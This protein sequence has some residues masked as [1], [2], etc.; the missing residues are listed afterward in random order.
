LIDLQ[1]RVA[2]VHAAAGNVVLDLSTPLRR[3]LD[4]FLFTVVDG[5]G[6]QLSGEAADAVVAVDAFCTQV[7]AGGAEVDDPSTTDPTGSG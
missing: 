1:T 6:R 5:A 4:G 2:S 7:M 3:Y